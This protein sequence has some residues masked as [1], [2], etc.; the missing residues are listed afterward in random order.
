[1]KHVYEKKLQASDYKEQLNTCN[2]YFPHI[3]L[4]LLSEIQLSLNK[5]VIKT[6]HT[7]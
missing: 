6:K 1:M 7:L 2:T 3:N 4:L 5:H